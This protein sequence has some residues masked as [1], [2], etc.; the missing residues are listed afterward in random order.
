MTSDA[1]DEGCALVSLDAHLQGKGS[2]TLT[3]VPPPQ[4]RPA[5]FP[6]LL[7]IIGALVS[8]AI[9]QADFGNV[10]LELYWLLIQIH[11]GTSPPPSTPSTVS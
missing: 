7:E 8:T 3:A 9:S 4:S 5:D 2:A 11:F 6:H 10:C 1:A